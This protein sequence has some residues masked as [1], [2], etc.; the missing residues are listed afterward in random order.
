MTF[1]DRVVR[2]QRDGLDRLVLA[3]RLRH[4]LGNVDQHGTGT[5]G[6]RDVESL[7]D[8]FGEIAHVLHEEVVLHARTRNA[9]GVA[10]LKRVE[11]D[12]HGRNLAADDDERN[13]IHIG[14]GDAGDGI[15]DARAGSHE[16]HAHFAGRTRIRV[17]GVHG[18]LLVAHENV[19][20]LVLLVEL[21]VDAEYRA[22]GITPDE[23]D[24]F[25]GQRA[26]EHGG[27]D[28]VGFGR[29]SGVVSDVEN[30]ALGM[31][32]HYLSNFRQKIDRVLSA[33]AR[34]SG[35]SGASSLG[36]AGVLFFL[37]SPQSPQSRHFTGRRLVEIYNI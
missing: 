34:G 35:S 37:G 25:I 17:G 31:F 11:A 30:S 6:T 29:R 5:A 7:F 23:F 14:R 33:R 22:A 13:G 15:G 2:T 27:A 4:V 28:G 18:G 9:D 26:H 1:G 10:L 36:L 21:V 19:L 12:G 3:R 20:N 32:I 8:G 24:V 16:A